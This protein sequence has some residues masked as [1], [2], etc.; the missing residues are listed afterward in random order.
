MREMKEETRR[1]Q[2]KTRTLRGRPVVAKIYKL[3]QDRRKWEAQ[4]DYF[5]LKMG[6]LEKSKKAAE[7]RIRQCRTNAAKVKRDLD[8]LELTKAQ[9]AEMETN[10][11]EQEEE[12]DA[13]DGD[14]EHDMECEDGGPSTGPAQAKS[15]AV[16]G[17]GDGGVGGERHQARAGATGDE[18]PL[19]GTTAN[20]PGQ[21]Q[22]Q[23]STP[24]PQAG[25]P[26]GGEAPEVRRSES[27]KSGGRG[28]QAEDAEEGKRGDDRSRS[29][30]RQEGGEAAATPLP[31]PHT[32]MFND[33]SDRGEESEAPATA[34]EAADVGQGG[35]RKK[36]FSRVAKNKRSGSQG[37]TAEDRDKGKAPRLSKSEQ[38]RAR[39]RELEA[40]RKAIREMEKESAAHAARE[41]ERKHKEAEAK[42][43]QLEQEEKEAEQRQKELLNREMHPESEED[44]ENGEFDE[45]KEEPASAKD[46]ATAVAA[47][48][49]AKEQDK[50]KI[51]WDQRAAAK[52]IQEVERSTKGTSAAT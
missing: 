7:D 39:E 23:P 46:A 45:K 8:A 12:M 32:G 36:W 16:A 34:G 3:E 4:R 35:N 51:A 37:P 14:D 2:Q 50:E 29:R 38:R 17:N 18:T 24:V 20:G 48:E 21:G 11:R 15:T 9:R 27:R 5:T 42:I 28:R 25:A 30:P 47:A 26:A 31:K 52:A 19:I 1:R 44:D 41:A 22:S 49:N 40:E 33:L 43:N 13:R 10:L 6:Q